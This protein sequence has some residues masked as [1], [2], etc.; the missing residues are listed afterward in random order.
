MLQLSGEHAPMEEL[1]SGGMCCI[2]RYKMKISTFVSPLASGWEP[3]CQG[4][5]CMASLGLSEDLGQEIVERSCKKKKADS[6]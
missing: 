4:P 2:N 3:L 1:D 5:P 6:H